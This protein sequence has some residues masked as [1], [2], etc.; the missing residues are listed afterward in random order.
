MPN[1]AELKDYLAEIKSIFWEDMEMIDRTN[2]IYRVEAC[3]LRDRNWHNI[4]FLVNSIAVNH[5]DD[6]HSTVNLTLNNRHFELTGKGLLTEKFGLRCWFGYRD[7]GLIFQKE[8]VIDTPQSDFP[9]GDFPKITLSGKDM[10]IEVSENEDIQVYSPGTNDSVV[11]EIA[12]DH[13]WEYEDDYGH[14]SYDGEYIP[15]KEDAYYSDD[16]WEKSKKADNTISHPRRVRSAISEYDFMKDMAVESGNVLYLSNHHNS[17]TGETKTRLHFHKPKP[18]KEVY[19]LWYRCPFNPLLNNV[20]SIS[21]GEV[22]YKRSATISTGT[23]DTYTGEEIL[24]ESKGS[25]TTLDKAMIKDDP[26]PGKPSYEYRYDAYDDGRYDGTWDGDRPYSGG[27]GRSGRRSAGHS[28]PSKEKRAIYECLSTIKRGMIGSR[29]IR[30][31]RHVPH[32]VKQDSVAAAE[33]IVDNIDS[34]SHFILELTVNMQY[35]LPFIFQGDIVRVSGAYFYDGLYYVKSVSHSK[36][37]DRQLETTLELRGNS[38]WGL[39]SAIE[40]SDNGYYDEREPGDFDEE[41]F[42]E[43]HDEPYDGFKSY[44]YKDYEGYHYGDEYKY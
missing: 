6:G 40:Y 16:D 11:R 26:R 44:F 15:D 14:Y 34:S 37:V 33:G 38:T 25:R 9:E 32:L 27:D 29:V 5:N 2:S 21:V 43:G 36:G 30:N 39:K 17:K 24:S 23:L 7:I 18:K 28:T 41:D 3:N 35:G 4:T 22:T 13:G 31:Y 1:I 19:E 42:D 10:M 20:K 12:E 8:F